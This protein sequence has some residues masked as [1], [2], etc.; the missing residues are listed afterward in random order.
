MDS[1][2]SLDELKNLNEC[3]RRVIHAE[4]SAKDIM[5]AI[6]MLTYPTFHLTIIGELNNHDIIVRQKDQEDWCQQQERS[7]KIDIAYRQNYVPNMCIDNTCKFWC[8]RYGRQTPF[9]FPFSRYVL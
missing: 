2:L 8:S 4:A 3:S 6:G 9:V 5:V 7:V 1:M